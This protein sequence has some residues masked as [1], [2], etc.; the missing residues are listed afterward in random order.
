VSIAVFTGPSLEPA[1]VTAALPGA[2]V[3][4]PAG[5]G[6]LA[7]A[8]G[9]GARTLLLIDGAFAHR[10]AVS[11]GEIVAAMRAGAR[12]VGAA[13]L[14]AV[15]AAECHP[16]GM[17]G[18]GAVAALYRHGVIRDD[19]E[20]AVAVEPERG[21][22]AASVALIN[23]RFAVLAALRRG[24]L[25]RASAAAVLGAARALHFSE[26]TWPA[27][28]AAAGIAPGHELLERCRATDVKRRDAELA[29]ARLA[30]ASGDGGPAAR[31]A[32]SSAA[33]AA[34]GARYGG[35]DPLLG[36]T[37]QALAPG[38][39]RW[40]EGSGRHRLYAGLLD[41]A[42]PEAVW[43]RLERDREL[44]SELM[45]WYAVHT[46]A[47]LEGSDD[48]AALAPFLAM[49]RSEIAAAHGCPGWA[50]LEAELRGRQAGEALARARAAA[51]A[52]ALARRN[53]RSATGSGA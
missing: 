51:Y 1:R 22:R 12:V 28:F 36:A 7:A 31:P 39:A 30:D 49:A 43:A 38:L 15:R 46:A 48:G 4:P 53:V 20:V 45:R 8:H 21:H 6:D 26:R 37:R 33:P 14:G 11:P 3:L 16:A 41:G 47:A 18:I 52:L 35:H 34:P 27:I 40:L 32:G 50:E 25:A 23:V 5:R 42:A 44:A 17:E 10:R 29:V 2:R 19:D 9:E 13:S 24:L